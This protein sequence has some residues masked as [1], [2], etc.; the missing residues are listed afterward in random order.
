MQSP[1]ESTRAIRSQSDWDEA[2]NDF[3]R[4]R[5]IFFDG[6][7]LGIK[8]SCLEALCAIHYLGFLL[9]DEESFKNYFW[10]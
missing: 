5:G 4:F 8:S 6:T 3:F 7:V 1:F 9:G 10:Q 2:E